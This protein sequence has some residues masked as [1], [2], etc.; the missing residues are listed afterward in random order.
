MSNYIPSKERAKVIRVALAKFFGSENVSVRKGTGTASSW[1]HA[2]VEAERPIG[3]VCEFT[4][5]YWNGEPAPKPYRK[6]PYCTAC[7]EQYNNTSE[8]M[9][10]LSNEAMK[11]AGYEHS[12]YYADDGYNSEH[13]EF[14]TQVD[15]K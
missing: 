10:K 4:S 15:V 13:S 6:N 8:A 3:C 9:R 12:T 5:T 11:Q 2:N 1:V 7:K 14:L